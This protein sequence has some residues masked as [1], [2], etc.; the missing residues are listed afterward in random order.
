MQHARILSAAVLMAVGAARVALAQTLPSGPLELANGTVTLA[1]EVAATIGARDDAIP[2]DCPPGCGAFFNY[3]DYQHNALRMFR[4]SFSGAW[5]PSR[6]FAFLTEVRSEDMEQFRA[7]AMYVRVRPWTARGFDVQVGRIPPVFGAYSR[8]VYGADNRLIGQPLAYQY[9]TSLR[10]D[11]VPASADDLLFMRGRGWL[12]SYP[13]VGVGSPAA[14][15]GVPIITAYQWDVGIEA[16]ID[17]QRIEAAAA[18]TSGTLSNPRVDDDNDGRQISARLGWKPFVGLVIGGSYA[19][20]EWLNGALR[21]QLSS[22]IAPEQ[23]FPQEAFG[24]DAEYS[25]DYWLVRG[26]V[27][28]SRWR[29][30][31]LSA[32]FIDGPLDATA[33]FVETRYR[34]TPRL[35]AAARLDGLTFSRIT[36]ERLF[37][38]VPTTWDAPVTRIEAGGGVY[39]QRN[40]IIRGV[41]QRN[42]RDGGLVHNRTF[43]SGQIAFWF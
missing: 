22:R 9:L 13:V 31:A 3:T 40:L 27:I 7:Y 34:F 21:N 35:F 28:R 25:R 43:V 16:S 24:F 10:S 29:L 17:T 20:G 38:G 5:R 32:P 14:A 37:T 42:W 12:A 1:A 23:R 19:H 2:P 36:G 39:I 8:R 11:A 41:V 18:I 4:V 30:P 33:A 15:P 6:R 26:E